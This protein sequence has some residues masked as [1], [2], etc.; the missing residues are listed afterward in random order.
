MYWGNVSDCV[1][2]KQDR[3]VE[4]ELL[5]LVLGKVIQG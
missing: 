1:H 4:G 5:V 3:C 2:I